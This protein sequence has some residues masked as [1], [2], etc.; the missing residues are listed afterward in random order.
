MNKLNTLQ[1]QAVNAAKSGDWQKASLI[2][3][4]ILAL[5]P[6]DVGA[7]NRL[8]LSYMQ[9]D[10]SPKAKQCFNKVLELDS[11]NSIAK[12]NLD[13]IKN[14]LCGTP[15]FSQE[16]FIEEPGKT[17]IVELHRLAGKEILNHLNP[18]KVCELKIKNRYISVES[19]GK[20][21]GTLPEDLSFRLTK[22]INRKNRYECFVHSAST[23]SCTIYIKEVERSA[24]NINIHSFPLNKSLLTTINDIDEKFLLEDNIPM[25]ILHTDLDLED[26]D[27]FTQRPPRTL[28]DDES[29]VTDDD[30]E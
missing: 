18:G 3:E 30:D 12:K 5:N 19:D 22:L 16:N 13:K 2:N 25:E 24:Q 26:G 8:G 6:T 1:L 17:K 27:D 29:P 21:I 10:K 11:S 9:L 4:E 23:K 15:N 14:K 7:L 20:Y 28:S